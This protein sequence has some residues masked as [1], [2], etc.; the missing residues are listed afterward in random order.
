MIE[1]IPTC[2]PRDAAD[3]S[4]KASAIRGYA[5]H[6]HIDITDGVFAPACTWP[7]HSKGSFDPFDLG[8]T[9]DLAVEIHLMVNDPLNIG[10]QFARAG[11]HR[12]LGHIEAFENSESARGALDAWRIEGAKEAGLGILMQT[13]LTV[14]EPAVSACDV[15]HMMTIARIGTQGIPY[16]KDAPARIAAFHAAYPKTL[17]SV[18][19]GVSEENIEALA[20]AGVS[21]FSVGS[22]LSGAR[23]PKE[24]MQKLKTLAEGARIV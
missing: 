14:I 4:K 16:E 22:A 24:L 19:G 2:V 15:V 9:K 13:P 6:I 10:I 17:I 18:D 7:Y 12:V 5:R 20:R 23:D 11:A 8:A 3:L 1:I 21:R